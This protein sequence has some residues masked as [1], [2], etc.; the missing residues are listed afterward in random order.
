MVAGTLGKAMGSYGAYVACSGEV[1]ELLINSARPLIFSTGLPP[2]VVRAAQ[3]ALGLIEQ[4]PDLLGRLHDNATV[5]RDALREQGLDTGRS[6]SQI[7][8]VRIGDPARTVAACARA[9]EQGVYAQAIRPPTVPEGTSRL[10]MTVMA[11]HHA[12]EL[13]DA[14]KVIGDSV[15]AVA[16]DGDWAL[17]IPEPE[18]EPEVFRTS[19]GPTPARAL[20]QRT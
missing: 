14:A 4:Q 2:A 19:P 6:K 10:R 16:A 1:R 12:S 9:L 8:P 13:R 7:I 18:G 17:E 15:R 5:L 11:S 20:D 3:A